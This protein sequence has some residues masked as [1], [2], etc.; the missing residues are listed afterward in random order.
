MDTTQI[1]PDD[2]VDI[3]TI[4]IDKNLSQVERTAEFLRQI[5]NP[6]RYKC[7]KVTVNVS[8]ADTN[9]TLEDRLESYL[10]SL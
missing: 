4:N 6:Y 7:G 10:S 2:L 3:R 1:D 8:F 9:E 5:K